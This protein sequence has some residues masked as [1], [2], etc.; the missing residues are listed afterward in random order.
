MGD[1]YK[2]N[3]SLSMVQFVKKTKNRIFMSQISETSLQNL[4]GDI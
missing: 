3:Q 1:E 4:Q 2:I